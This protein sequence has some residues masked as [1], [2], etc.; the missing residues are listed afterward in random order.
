MRV[1][2]TCGPSYEPLDQV[3]R[4]TNF[5]T[6]EL[7]VMLVNALVGH[8][9]ICLKGAGATTA[10]G[11]KRAETISFTT[12]EDLLARLMTISRQEKIDAVFHAAALSDFKVAAVRD[13]MGRGLHLSKVP[14]SGTLTVTLEPAAKL[15]SSF[16]E[17]FP[18]ALIVGWKYEL[19][20]AREEAVSRAM[21]QIEGD[22]IDACVLNGA[23]YGP[24]FGFC[25]RGIAPR[26]FDSKSTLVDFLACW[27]ANPGRP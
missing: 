27:L 22:R 11:I 2:V 8:E 21:Q 23:A 12:N 5:S 20:G 6:G 16:R 3:R 19:N 9:V 4:L 1:V 17:L 26:H 14:S 24:G 15:L 25:T 10:L 7:G 13:S 18:D